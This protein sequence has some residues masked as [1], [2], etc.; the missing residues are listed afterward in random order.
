MSHILVSCSGCRT[1]LRISATTKKSVI[2]CPR[3]A[4]QIDIT[5]LKDE[6]LKADSKPTPSAATSPRTKAQAEQKPVSRE[7]AAKQQAAR[8]AQVVIPKKPMLPRD[9]HQDDE[10]ADE[11]DEDLLRAKR[12]TYIFLGATLAAILAAVIVFPGALRMLQNTLQPAEVAN[13]D[14]ATDAA[15][16]SP[17][18][19][20]P[21]T[22]ET[23]VATITASPPTP[24]PAAPEAGAP[25]SPAAMPPANES[26][27]GKDS[28]AVA[29]TES[30]SAAAPPN[31]SEPGQTTPPAPVATPSTEEPKA[32][33]NAA[34]ANAGQDSQPAIPGSNAKPAG[35]EQ[36]TE[37]T[38]PDSAKTVR[39]KWQPGQEHVYTLKIEA[40]HDGSKQ[41][42]NGSCTYKVK[43]KASADDSEQ[44]G[45]G[46]GFVITSDGYIGTCAH[47]VD[48]AKRIEI[49][50]DGKTYPAK[51]IS[52]NKALDLAIVRIEASGLNVVRFGDSEKV[53][54]AEN[55]RAFGFPLSTVLGTGI[56]V[57]TGTVSGIV[58]DTRH[59]KQ[60]Q[61]DAPINPGNSGGPIVNESGQVIGV[62]S[63]KLA[64]REVSSVGFAV[65]VNA[66]A[67]MM[68]EKGLKVP[69][70]GAAAKL[71]G[72]R[73]AEQVTPTVAFLKV[74]GHR[75]GD[76]FDVEYSASI[77]QS[78]TIDVRQL[79]FGG[80]PVF[81]SSS[82]DSGH[83]KV[84]HSGEITEYS[85]NESLPYVLGPLGQFFIEPLGDDGDKTWGTESETSVRVVRKSD[86]GSPF[87]RMRG[88]P[89]GP[90]GRFGS[91]FEP[92]PEE[93]IKVVPATESTH[94]SFGPE[95]NGRI[96]IRKA[97]EFVTTDNEQSPF[98]KVNGKG[99][100]TFDRTIG[101][102]VRLQYEATLEQNS[103]DH[104]SVRIP[105][106]VT[107]SLKTAEEVAQE[108]E[109]ARQRAEELKKKKEAEKT[110]PNPELVTSVLQEIRKANGG[111]SAL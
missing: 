72:P 101:M 89:F 22:N 13:S 44:E 96:T 70:S 42:I 92:Q 16:T 90:R 94:Y 25:K 95:L 41:I 105:L 104:Q 88:L 3:C 80:M 62:A 69:E 35:V 99:D 10:F 77:V 64:S 36:K 109:Q 59:G 26:G 83:M 50:L 28:T 82:R 40:D 100:L 9:P 75:G 31:S 85:G 14:A 17:Q 37:P 76:M 91:P 57:V 53:Q 15:N 12:E 8:R 18:V 81:P 51:V 84:N 66:L 1:K 58:M 93:T 106:T 30:N 11:I 78:Q 20:A 29:S 86:N 23:E 97:Y 33:G 61:T 24:N 27:D 48:G 21:S 79:R 107:W 52:I 63:S 60:I 47:V 6:A 34:V 2:E 46:S 38:N 19:T 98:L 4:E 102:P 5:A 65:P 7:A 108:R 73:L 111:I 87:S 68:K 43:A 54:L 32:A 39:Y 49:T 67:D 56:K 71:D 110:Q 55:V 103:E 74:W 45:S